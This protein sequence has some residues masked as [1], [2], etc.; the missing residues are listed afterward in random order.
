MKNLS[1][2]FSCLLCI[3]C[4]HAPQVEHDVVEPTVIY[5]DIESRMPGSLMIFNHYAIWSD[6]FSTDDQIH[7][8]NLQTNQEIGKFL[9]IGNGPNEFITPNYSLT[10]NNNVIVYDMSQ[11]KMS[12][13]SIDSLEKQM[14]PLVMT[15]K[16]ETQSYTRI[17]DTQGQNFVK[18]KPDNKYPFLYGQQPF[19]KY[20]FKKEEDFNNKFDVLQGNIAYNRDNQTLVYSTLGFPYI[21][22]YKKEEQSDNFRL[23]WER[24][25]DIDYYVS[26]G[27]MILDRTRMGVMELALTKDYIVTVQR[28]Y[29]KDPTD[30]S[31][32]GRDFS[33]LPQTLFVYD[34]QSN[35]KRIIDFKMP[36]LR[37]GSDIK[38]NTIYAIVVNP[39][40]CLVKYEL[41]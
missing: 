26:E 17:I 32:V 3:T 29:Q 25:G 9:D 24:K 1:L 39:D 37:I 13:Y 20:P 19:G 31:R 22:A 41:S 11:D 10:S 36:I 4:S 40:F 16:A 23:L 8:I 38:N 15:I 27:K 14:Y 6:P 35:L 2:I 34:Y 21:A 28:D 7:V 12:F 5:N 33:M 30:E 18:F